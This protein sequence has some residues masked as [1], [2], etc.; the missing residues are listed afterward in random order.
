MKKKE[1]KDK[2]SKSIDTG[3]KAAQRKEMDKAASKLKDKV[4]MRKERQSVIHELS[5]DADSTSQS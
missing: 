1:I 4:T 3:M 5:S 2:L